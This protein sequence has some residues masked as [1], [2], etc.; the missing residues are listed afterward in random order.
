M[1]NKQYTN[2]LSWQ[3]LQMEQMPPALLYKLMAFRESIFVVE[4]ACPYQELDGRDEQAWHLMGER[5][6]HVLACLRVLLP[7]T[8]NK[9]F[10]IGRVAVD[11]IARG[12][13]LAREMLLM[14]E[15]KIRLHELKAE[16]VLDAQTYL[17]PFYQA[18]G[19]QISGDEF[20]EDGIPHRPMN[21]FLNGLGA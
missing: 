8:G 3:W 15:Q 7:P 1:E 6:G 5:A 13:G 9:R 20:L 2:D 14:A 21:K 11:E 16:I 10:R 12:T 4:Q 18:M 19:Y 17:L